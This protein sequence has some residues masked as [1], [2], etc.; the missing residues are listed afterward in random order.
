MQNFANDYASREYREQRVDVLMLSAEE[1]GKKLLL[2]NILVS[3]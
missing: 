2:E 3:A 1:P